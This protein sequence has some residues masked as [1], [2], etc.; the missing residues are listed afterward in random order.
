MEQKFNECKIRSEKQLLAIR[1]LE[2]E[3]A[4]ANQLIL[5]KRKWKLA[6]KEKN[7]LCRKLTEQQNA[8]P[9]EKFKSKQW[10]KPVIGGKRD[11]G[12]L[13][14]ITPEK[15]CKG[16]EYLLRSRTFFH[17]SFDG[18]QLDNIR[19]SIKK[20]ND[21]YNPEHPD[22]LL[23]ELI[24]SLPR[25]TQVSENDTIDHEKER[26][27]SEFYLH[28]K[29]K[30]ADLKAK[31]QELEKRCKHSETTLL[32]RIREL[33][34]DRE[35]QSALRKMLSIK[36]ANH[37]IQSELRLMKTQTKEFSRQIQFMK[38]QNIPGTKDISNMMEIVTRMQYQAQALL[39]TNNLFEART[40]D[41]KPKIKDPEKDALLIDTITVAISKLQTGIKLTYQSSE[42]QSTE[43]LDA[44]NAINPYSS[45]SNIQ[46]FKELIRLMQSIND[47]EENSMVI[48]CSD[49]RKTF[50]DLIQKWSSVL[51]KEELLT[52][53]SLPENHDG[54]DNILQSLNAIQCHFVENEREYLNKLEHKLTQNFEKISK[55][56]EEVVETQKALDERRQIIL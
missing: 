40:Q 1:K 23:Q 56:T 24:A 14:A 13:L 32:H 47:L 39:T 22:K 31:K 52:L 42:K 46:L 51:S 11:L 4:K 19:Q 9:I 3:I 21:P 38:D 5:E 37:Q 53:D 30:V 12:L 20:L 34:H 54:I 17:L 29:S 48:I 27:L 44:K 43:L 6:I 55:A 35:V 49:I 7:A 15:I 41:L 10:T 26:V 25:I 45:I 2:S 8:Y 50:E 33:Y 28:R 16:I 36:A 18:E